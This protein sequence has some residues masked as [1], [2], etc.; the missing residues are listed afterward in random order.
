MSPRCCGTNC[1]C[2]KRKGSKIVHVEIIFRYSL[3]QVH[4]LWHS[5]NWVFCELGVIN[6]MH[7][8]VLVSVSGSSRVA[9]V[10]GGWP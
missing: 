3:P 6:H 2:A 8:P 10:C 9:F 5:S 4:C 1:K 7:V